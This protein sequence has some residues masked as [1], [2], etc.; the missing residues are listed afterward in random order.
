MNRT[1]PDGCHVIGR[2]VLNVDAVDKLTG[3]ARL[4]PDINVPQMSIC[5]VLR[6][7]YAH[8]RV[9]GVDTTRA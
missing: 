9:R 5:K 3:T 2:S 4:S 6:S 7:I 1:N 8:A